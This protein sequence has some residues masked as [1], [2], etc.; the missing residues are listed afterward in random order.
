MPSAEKIGKRW[1]G[2]ARRMVNGEKLKRT[3]N[4]DTKREALAWARAEEERLEV[5]IDFSVLD[6]LPFSYL[7]RRYLDEVTPLKKSARNERLRLNRFLADYPRLARKPVSKFGRQDVVAW[8]EHRSRCVSPATVTREWNNLSAIFSYAQKDWGLPLPE[9][10]FHMV[11]RP[12]GAAPRNQRISAEAA[13]AIIEALG[14]DGQRS[15][16]RQSEKVAWAFLFAIETAMRCGEICKLTAEDVRDG[17]AHLRDTK[18]GDDR[19]VPLSP[20][21]RRLLA[22]IELP[23][24]ITPA[25]VDALFRKYRSAELAHI[26]FHDTRHEALSRM[27]QKI[28]NPMTLA[29]ISGHKDVKILL[30]TY[31]NPQ[32]ED[33]AGLLG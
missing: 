30:N 14:Y 10:P 27:A 11:R 19:F 32:G 2:V 1:K 7:I 20:E 17:I 24:G 21:A 3:K 12:K 28:H 22:L 5:G 23:L 29:K 18:N 15:P 25:Q 6:A 26:R 31:Y 33:L 8:K 4:F 9:N 13:K 16:K